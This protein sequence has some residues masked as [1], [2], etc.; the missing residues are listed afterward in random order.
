MIRKVKIEDNSNLLFD[1]A[2]ELEAFRNGREYEFKPGINI[3][4]GKN[5]CGKSTLVKQLSSYMLCMGGSH[6]SLPNTD[7][8]GGM[9]K[10]NLFFNDKDALRD[11]IKIESDYLGVAYNYVSHKEVNKEEVFNSVS[12]LG[13]YLD[14]K[15]SSTGESGVR[16]LCHLLDFAFKNKDVIFPVQKLKNLA[17]TSNE[18]W[19]DKLYQLLD[20]YDKNRTSINKD[21]F[22]YT[23][24]L[25]EPDRNLDI[26]YIDELY[27]ML[28]LHKSFTQIIC[29]I[30]NPILIYKL[31]K[32]DHVN[33]VEM[34]DG[35]L[36]KIKEVF[37]NL[38]K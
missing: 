28:S 7:M 6:S 21:E 37:D 11:G 4:V 19:K 30:H 24:L 5:G 3:I 12:S 35:Y 15:S 10:M 14:N 26:D 29:V 13:L 2:R 33:F 1:Y 9:L 20:Y 18:Y 32:V 8:E 36:D 23:F 27:G 34:S 31:N 16:T 22:E 38:I 25:D 17:D